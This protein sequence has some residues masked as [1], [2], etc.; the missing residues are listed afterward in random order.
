MKGSWNIALPTLTLILLASAFVN[1]PS[2]AMVTTSDKG[3][4]TEDLI[5]KFYEDL[6]SAYSALNACIYPVDALP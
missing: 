5:I 1:T 2:S 4:R 6:E 3:P